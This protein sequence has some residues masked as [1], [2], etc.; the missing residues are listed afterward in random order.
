MRQLRAVA[1]QILNLFWETSA[2]EG[3]LW[4]YFLLDPLDGSLQY[5]GLVG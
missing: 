5:C 4:A 2:R 3:M 1:F